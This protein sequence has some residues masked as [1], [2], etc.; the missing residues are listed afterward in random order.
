MNHSSSDTILLSIHPSHVD[1]IVKGIK[2]FELR[3][4]IPKHIKQIA[5]Y[6]TAPE[7]RIV[8]ICKVEEI[9]FDSPDTLWEKVCGAAAIDYLFYK[10]YF[11][12]AK[13]AY[14]IRLGR[15][16]LISRK[17]Q[18]SHPR[19]QKMPPQ[20]FIYLDEKQSSWL[21]DCSD[22][23]ISGGTKKIFIGGIHGSGKSYLSAKIIPAFGYYCISASQL[24]EDGRGEVN[25]DK[26]VSDIDNNQRCLLKGLEKI[27]E[28]H[29]HLA[30]DGH[31][32][33]LDR[34]GYVKIIPQKTF[35]DINPELMLLANPTA[36]VI[37]KRLS[38]RTEKI[39]IR[40]SIESF[41]EK[42]FV[43]AQELA[44]LFGIPLHVMD[45]NQTDDC[46]RQQLSR[47]LH[48]TRLLG[49]M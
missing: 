32:C 49:C 11:A 45:T 2:R 22:K 1:N 44:R 26:R 30:I 19:L 13:V 48:D 18:L 31:F 3:R 6:S 10:R 21:F 37:K 17:I 42:E 33:L 46:M 34:Y 7:S 14:A 15:L 41:Q 23:M 16:S 43:Y 47:F 35:D 40:C 39:R 36:D 5:I 4:R 9:I 20:S 24:I 12:S 28:T 25:T 38:T 27:Q 29:S 8:G